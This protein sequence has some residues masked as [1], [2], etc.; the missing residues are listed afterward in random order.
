MPD[1][2]GRRT[3]ADLDEIEALAQENVANL[4]RA[5]AGAGG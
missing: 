4:P 3:E 5:V 2:K 1:A